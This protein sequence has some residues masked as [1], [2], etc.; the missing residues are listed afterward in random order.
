MTRMPVLFVSHG[1]PNLVLHDSPCHRFLGD[2]GRSLPRPR[3]VL[4]VSAHFT[5]RMPAVTSD[6][7]PQTIYDF[8][9]FE[10]E[11]YQMTYEAPGAPDVARLCAE[12]LAAHGVQAALLADR[13]FDHGTWVPLKLML[14]DADIPVVQLSVQPNA[15]PAHHLAVGKALADL[16]GQGILIVGSGALT[17]NLH[18]FFAAGYALTDPAPDWVRAF[19]DWM[20]ERIESG[21]I[22][23][24]LKY[25]QIAPTGARNH[26]TEEHLLP[27]FTALGAAAGAPGRRLHSS[28][29]YG[30][31]MMDVYGFGMPEA[32]QAA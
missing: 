23:E 17:H 29:Q 8:G 19:G 6:A 11:L 25:R 10:P 26:P 24:L 4:V 12:A 30:V 21:R 3:A 32:R 20:N 15:G 14:P 13:G 22:D 2:L 28:A 27:L 5:T 9:G 31:L 18:E 1:A 16:A 7:R